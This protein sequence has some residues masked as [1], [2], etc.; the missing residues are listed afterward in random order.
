MY[1]HKLWME[2][3]RLYACYQHRVDTYSWYRLKRVHC[4]KSSGTK[5]MHSI[6]WAGIIYTEVIK[7]ANKVILR[8]SLLSVD[9]DKYVKYVYIAVNFIK[10]T[11]SNQIF[12]NEFVCIHYHLWEISHKIIECK[13]FNSLMNSI[14]IYSML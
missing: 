5:I 4:R 7:N 11:D 12:R 13:S 6:I 10:L 14:T 1:H 2:W 8:I 3:Y 9:F